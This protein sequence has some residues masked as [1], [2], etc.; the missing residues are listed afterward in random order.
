MKYALRW[1]AAAAA[2]LMLSACAHR[3]PVVQSAPGYGY[4]SAPVYGPPPYENPPPYGHPA[5]YGNPPVYSPSRQGGYYPAQPQ[6]P[7]AYTQFGRVANIELVSARGNTSGGGALLGGLV[8]AVVGRQFGNSSDGR[9]TGTMLGAF[10]GAVIGNEI[11]R[12]Q[13][14]RRD[15]VRVS[16]QLDRGGIVAFDYASIGDLR[17][18]D[19]VRIEGSRVYRL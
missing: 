7:G 18:G 17:I 14:G 4:G 2:L 5:P 15:H 16:I 8:G 1:G 19:R 10:G 13:H 9:A 3:Q 6:Y 11:E 12:D